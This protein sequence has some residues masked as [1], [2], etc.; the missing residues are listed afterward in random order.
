MVD[1][2]SFGA[3]CAVQGGEKGGCGGVKRGEDVARSSQLKVLFG[4]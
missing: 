3:L 2:G 4:E 1:A